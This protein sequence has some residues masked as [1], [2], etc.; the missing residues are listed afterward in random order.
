MTT[1]YE[2]ASALGKL[3]ADVRDYVATKNAG[4]AVLFG[5]KER[6]IQ[7]NQGSGGANRIVFIPGRLPGGEA[8]EL[9]GVDGPGEPNLPKVGGDPQ[10]KPRALFL[11]GK[12]ATISIW[13]AN[14][15][16]DPSARVDEL[17]QDAAIEQM[18]EWVIRGVKRSVAGAAN[19]EWGPLRYNMSPIETKFGV[20]LLVELT[21]GTQYF[22]DVPNI[23][24]PTG[25]EVDRGAIS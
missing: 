1:T 17:A 12:L 9:E 10:V 23:V 15:D 22:D 6:T 16:N 24:Y 21:V 18:L 2:N 3:F 13:A 11:H 19:A 4:T 7:I 14:T 20:E 8:G 5:L 25:V